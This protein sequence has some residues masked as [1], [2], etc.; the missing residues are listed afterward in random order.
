[1]S[2]RTHLGGDL[3]A[4]DEGTRVTLAG[5]VARRR[6]HGGLVFVD[7][8]DQ[9]G[10]VQLVFNPDEQP[11]AHA[12]AHSLRS[13]FVI[14]AEG[15]VR[16]RSTE[17]VNPRLETGRIEVH[18]ERLEVLA[19]APVLPFQLDDEGVD[20]TLRLRHRYLDLR[21]EEMR[22]N[23]HVRF[24]LT[25]T[26]RRYLE[27]RGF[28][29]LETPI[30]YKST[31]EG[32]RE[33]LVPT[34]SHPG[35]FYALPQSPQ[36]YKQLY[37]ISGFERYY[38]I[39]RCFRDEATRADRTAEFTQLDMELGFIEP[40]ELFELIEGMFATIW[41]DLMDDELPIPFPRM[42]HDE[43][44]LRYAMDKPDTRF[45]C[46]IAD[47][48]DALRDTEF[49]A[50]RAVIDDGGVVRGFAVS[51]AMDFSRKDFDGL[52][53]F[54]RTWGGK[55][56]AWMQ[57]TAPGEVR[58]P[59]AK[60]LADD[61]IAAIVTGIGAGEGDTI[62]L[63]ADAVDAAVRVLGPLRLHLGE[64]LGLIEQ[65]WKPLWITDFPM[66]EWLPDENRWKAAHNPF[67]APEPEFADTFDADP[68]AARARQYDF[69]LNGNEIGGGSIRN[70]RPEMQQ[71]VFRLLGI[72]EEEA[73]AKFSFLLR[74]L[75]MGAPPHGGIAFGIDRLAML[76]AGAASLRDVTAFPK[77]QGGF[78]PLTGAP[79]P[80]TSAELR[81][82]GI[83]VVT[84]PDGPATL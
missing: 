71:R 31:P 26:I 66:F 11:A 21:R 8:R 40:D 19:T 80:A 75:E 30:L 32:A 79:T 52:V 77:G 3:R 34:S 65:G 18:V 78:D 44:M 23:I 60:F 27:D 81:Q 43:A 35:R 24:K 5:W 67:S 84:D 68:A 72:S 14:Q 2:W 62:L 25:R 12:A 59:V 82:Y 63:V 51:G 38:Q 73:E 36:T 47:V 64:R 6:D 83:R 10:L 41:R 49:K 46:E 28:W 69:V 56:V 13:E 76:I 39:A 17:T 74:A 4:G 50:F 37:V 58:S 33:F 9:A 42:P 20:E 7:L 54:A 16:A 57:V 15:V 1:V 22:R 55:G 70:H 53:E 45:G 48:T 61:E 29:E